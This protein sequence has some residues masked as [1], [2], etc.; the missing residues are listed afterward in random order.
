MGKFGT[1]NVVALFCC[2][3]ALAMPGVANAQAAS[4]NA[5]DDS[6]DIIVTATRDSRSLKDVAMTVNVV[7]GDQLAKLKIFDVKD[8]SQLAPGLLLSNTTGR[9]NTTSLRGQNFNPDQGTSP[10]VQFYLNEAVTDAQIAYTAIYDVGQIEVLRG[11]QGLLRGA[12]APAGAITISTV[13]PKFDTTE[14]YVRATGTDLHGYNIQGGVTIPLGS[15]FSVRIAG[16]AD[17][18]RINQVRNVNRG[19][20]YSR[21]RTE[22]GR[23]TLG[24][25]PSDDFKGYL[26]F[27]YLSSRNNQYQQV[28]GAGNTPF[29]IYSEIN[30]S[31]PPNPPFLLPAIFAGGSFATN[32]AIRSGPAAAAGDYIAVAEGINQTNLKSSIIN[33]G[34]D[35]DIGGMKLSFVGAHSRGN[36]DTYRDL[37]VGNAIPGY[38]PIQHVFVPQIVDSQELRLAS[39]N[40][41]GFGGGVGIFH[42]KRSGTVI[43]EQPNDLFNYAVSPGTFVKSPLGPGGSFITVP[44][45]LALGVLAVVPIQSE[46]TSFNA[47]A[48]YFSGPLKIEAGIR[49]SILNNTQTFQLT[50]T[51]FSNSGP[52]E[53]IPANLQHFVT[54]PITGGVTINYAVSDSANLYA[55]YNHS[56]RS[57][58]TGVATPVGISADLIR[59]RDEKTDAY[60]VG[61]KGALADRKIRYAL[62]A[63]YQNY[64]GYISLIPGIRWV[65]AADP[66]GAGFFA[67]NY[68]GDATIKGVELTLDTQPTPNWDLGVAMSYAHGR[69]K[70]ARLPCNDYAGTGIPNQTGAPRVTGTGNVSYCLSNGKLGQF[71]DFTLTANTEVRFPIGDLTPYVR[72]L[73][74][75]RPAYFADQISYNY[76]SQTLLNVFVGIRGAE[77]KWELSVFARNLLNQ[78]RITTNGGTQIIVPI[79]AGQF[80]SGYNTVNTM[81]PR[82]FGLTAGFKF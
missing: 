11:P 25:K 70:N 75:Y 81:N 68:N 19:N 39:T 36:T 22:S 23:V 46:T 17:G 51:G 67:F 48:H 57:G 59:T 16:L 55:A 79:I 73:L 10:T 26:T 13:R 24:F 20:D 74:N 38:S 66:S 34:F 60:E 64:N 53:V 8:I 69:Y 27:Q 33:L 80:V 72:A 40:P 6:G 42:Y 44:N 78:R 31:P 30:V 49:Y 28:V 35:W 29:G 32:T 82:E 76:D 15:M 77:D 9:N 3:S 4:A 63:F 5:A 52:R 21:S 50:T 41:E 65:S 45:Q 1:T 2:A 12:L 7:T 62:S 47:N 71:P 14:G 43:S 56:Y 37:D 61:V 54:R 58:T 18:N